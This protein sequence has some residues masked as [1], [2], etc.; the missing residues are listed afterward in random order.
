M[1]FAAL[2]TL[3]VCPGRFCSPCPCPPLLELSSHHTLFLFQPSYLPEPSLPRGNSGIHPLTSRGVSQGASL[4]S[5]GHAPFPRL[6]L[7]KY[8]GTATAV[9]TRPN[10]RSRGNDTTR[11]NARSSRED[12]LHWFTVPHLSL[13]GTVTPAGF[14]RPS[15]RISK[16][17]PAQAGR[18]H[19]PFRSAAHA[20]PE[21]RDAMP[22]CR[23]PWVQRHGRPPV[24]FCC[25]PPVGPQWGEGEGGVD[26]D[27]QGVRGLLTT[28]RPGLAFIEHKSG[29]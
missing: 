8:S 13:G 17:P 9:S 25:P 21:V 26:E 14:S 6:T 19:F 24:L 27:Q 11:E 18:S 5:R 4:R 2:G 1:P 7:H 22:H 20:A 29:R 28:H 16:G 12:R 15:W 3:H 10:S 23:T